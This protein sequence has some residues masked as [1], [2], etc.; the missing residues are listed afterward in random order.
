VAT[1]A[2]VVDAFDKLAKNTGKRNIY[3]SASIFIAR[4]R[5]DRDLLKK[6]GWELESSEGNEPYYR[7][8]R[9]KRF[10]KFRHTMIR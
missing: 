6:N 3:D 9:G 7:I 8:V 2:D 10:L 4:L 5:N 1:S